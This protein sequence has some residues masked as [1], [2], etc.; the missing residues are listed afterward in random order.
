MRPDV[1]V[2]SQ[3]SLPTNLSGTIDRSCLS[4]DHHVSSA[5]STSWP[6]ARISTSM[7]RGRPTICFAAKPAPATTGLTRSMA[8]GERAAASLASRLSLRRDARTGSVGATSTTNTSPGCN[9]RTVDDPS[10][11]IAANP[12]P[13]IGGK[14]SRPSDTSAGVD[15]VLTAMATPQ[16]AC[17]ASSRSVRTNIATAASGPESARSSP[18]TRLHASLSASA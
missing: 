12:R 8:T 10:V 13:A 4:A 16:L 18:L 1:T 14:G 9:R 5:A 11:A 7:V 2:A 3:R 6:S 17:R 15:W